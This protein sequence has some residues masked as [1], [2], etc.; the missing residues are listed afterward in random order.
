M[1]IVIAMAFVACLFA[2]APASATVLKINGTFNAVFGY[3]DTINAA[4]FSATFDDSSLG[5]LLSETHIPVTLDTFTMSPTPYGGVTFDT[6]NVLF[7]LVY[8]QFEVLAGFNLGGIDN[9][10]NS[11]MTSHDPAD[12]FFTFEVDPGGDTFTATYAIAVTSSFAA[13]TDSPGGGGTITALPEPATMGLLLFGA[14][15]A[16]ARRRRG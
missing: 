2:A 3:P 12:F 16:L 8:T 4:A 14:C 6:S 10:L 9:G 1:R 15:G 5:D 13:G 7:E 11:V